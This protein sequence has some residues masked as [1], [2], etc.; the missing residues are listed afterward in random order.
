MNPDILKQLPDAPE[1]T[2]QPNQYDR[3]FYASRLPAKYWRTRI[4][5]SPES[6]LLLKEH[7][8][9]KEKRQAFFQGRSIGLHLGEASLSKRN[10]ESRNL[11]AAHEVLYTVSKAIILLGH[12]ADNV[13]SGDDTPFLRIYD[14]ETVADHAR[15]GGS[16]RNML[17]APTVLVLP[18]LYNVTSFS[19]ELRT[20]VC[21]SLIA[22]LNESKACFLYH[23][24]DGMKKTELSK[25]DN[26]GYALFLLY[27]ASDR[28]YL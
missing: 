11:E 19:E 25:F 3:F 26:L 7:V 27:S 28:F 2:H 17:L 18:D 5:V 24:V 8:M 22:R 12:I 13:Q 16:I 6:A 20:R 9:D 15:D 23:P 10:C 4:P 14:M 1:E 21:S